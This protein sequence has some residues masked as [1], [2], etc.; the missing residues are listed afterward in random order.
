MEKY[1]PI[2]I[3]LSGILLG[4]FLSYFLLRKEKFTLKK[5]FNNILIEL[6]I[7]GLFLVFAFSLDFNKININVNYI[8]YLIFGLIYISTL[9]VI[10]ITDKQKNII[11][12]AALFVGIVDSMIYSIYISMT[13]GFAYRY[14]IYLFILLLLLLVD[15]LLL[16][17]KLKSN[18]LINILMLCIYI[19]I[20]TSAYVFILTCILTTFALLFVFIIKGLSN[21]IRKK[22]KK[23]I[24]MKNIPILLFLSIS[25]IIVM[26]Y[27]NFLY[28]IM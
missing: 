16:K 8:A 21:V 5:V 28:H 13:V 11:N 17:E 27:T 1:I 15:T 10:A 12:K 3:F 9:L 7:G 26:I 23:T 18:Y 19:L 24:L 14:I 25:N 6:L 4:I 2:Y 22:E 20:F